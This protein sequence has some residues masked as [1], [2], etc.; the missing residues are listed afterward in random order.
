MSYGPI[1][2]QKFIKRTLRLLKK[3][4]GKNEATMLYNAMLGLLVL[5]KEEFLEDIPVAPEGDLPAWGIRP[6]SI[7][8][9]GHHRR[10]TTDKSKGEQ[11]PQ[12]T[13]YRENT[14]PGLVHSLRNA[15]V[16]FGV[17]PMDNGAKV[18]GFEFKDEAT[19]GFHAKLTIAE[20]LELCT[21]LARHVIRH[22]T[23][24]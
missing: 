5:P 13:T 1:W 12:Y 17:E 20:L 19:N 21:K 9:F 6:G 4:K 18:T 2:K 16:H 10:R 24:V 22:G 8:D 3:Y 11:G 23:H 14:L 15:V 7:K